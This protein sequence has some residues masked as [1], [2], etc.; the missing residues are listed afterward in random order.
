MELQ[1]P[2]SALSI[3]IRAALEAGQDIMDIYTDPKQDFGLLHGTA[4]RIPG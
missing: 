1:T 3:A 4:N 2:K